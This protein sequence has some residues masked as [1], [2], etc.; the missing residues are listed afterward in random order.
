VPNAGLSAKFPVNTDNGQGFELFR[1][2]QSE[3]AYEL[4]VYAEGRA[5]ATRVVLTPFA[6]T[7]DTL[8][9]SGV[10]AFGAAIMWVA[11]GC[12]PFTGTH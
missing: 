2:G 10:I 6:V 9:V 1:D 12:P 3:G 5:T 8:M 11:S 7:G 4:P